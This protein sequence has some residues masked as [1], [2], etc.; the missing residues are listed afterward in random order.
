MII[1]KLELQG[2]KSFPEKTK[3]LFHSGVTVI[4]G[5][6]G[7]GKSNIVDALLWVLGGKRFRTLRGERSTDIIFNGH[8]N[9]P[10]LSMADVNLT[11]DDDHEEEII[12]NHRFFRS[13]E[14]EYRLN[15]KL[16]RLMDIQDCLWKKAIGELRYF[17]I[18][19]GSIGL[20]LN[21]KP[22]EK[23]VL[24]EEAAGTAFYK[25][26]KAQAESKL[27]SS[28]QNLIRLE[29]I[30]SE[31]SRAKNSLRRQASAATKYRK[32]RDRIRSLTSL[33]F[34]KKIEELEKLQ[35]EAVLNHEKLISEENAILSRIKEEERLLAAKRKESWD[36]EKSI[37]EG[38]ENLYSLK[39]QL[40]RLETD[41]DQ[42]QRRISLFDEKKQ[43]AK[44]SLQEI[45]EEMAH[46]EKESGEAAANLKEFEE[47]LE[48]KRKALDEA[49]QTIQ[50][51]Q[52]QK[53]QKQKNIESLRREYFE[54]L[55]TTTETKNEKARFEK[56]WEILLRQE[57]KLQ[58]QLQEEKTYLRQSQE[59][60]KKGLDEFEKAQK[61]R[62]EAKKDLEISQKELERL[63]STIQTLQ[64]NIADIN[65]KIEKER[66]HLQLL[67]KIEREERGSDLTKDLPS[68]MGML[69]DLIHSDPEYTPLVDIFWKEEV[70]AQLLRVEDFLKSLSQKELRGNFFLLHPKKKKEAPSKEAQDPRVLGRFKSF[71]KVSPNIKD[72]VSS[73]EEA[74]VVKDI[75]SAVELWLQFPSQNYVTL[76]GD[77]LLSSGL[78]K[79]GTKKEG[80]YAL[81]HD[82]KKLEENI[83]DLGKRIHPLE[84]ETQEKTEKK[85]DLERK[86]AQKKEGLFHLEKAL[87]ENEKER[88]LDQ[89][90]K[91]KIELHISTLENEL[92]IL[93]DN[94]SQMQRRLQS[95]ASRLEASQKEELALKNALQAAEI[96]F[97]AYQRENE[98]KRKTYF[99][100]K[101]EID[102]LQERIKNLNQQ[103][104]T[105]G[106]RRD[107]LQAK[108]LS[109]QEEIKSAEEK[110]KHLQED[111]HQLKQKI[112]NLEDKIKLKET[113][114]VQS[115]VHLKKTQKEQNDLEQR[116]EGLREEHEAKKEERVQWEIRKAEK[117]RDLANLEESCW[118]ELRKT[119]EEVKK[120]VT[121]DMLKE[122]NIQEKL[123]DAREK[124][125]KFK[126]VNLM[127][128]E[129]YLSQKKRYDFLIQQ[130]RDLRESIDTTK[131]A[132]KKID[133]ES[134][135]QFFKALAEINK[136]F[137]DVFALLFKGG[138]AEL[139]LTDESDPLES[140]VE[141]TA[142][143]PGKRLQSI[144]LLSGGE[145]SLTSLAFFFALFRYKPTPFCVLDEVD[146]ALDDVNLERY[147]NLMRRIKNQTQFILITHNFKT[148][149]V[150]DYIYGTTMAEPNITTIYSVKLDKKKPS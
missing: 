30:I 123:E 73:F 109:F 107:S 21:S 9:K 19:Q 62:G 95:I 135:A 77:L 79:L 17:V 88:A 150:A 93:G 14:S 106:R 75:K 83:A 127:A 125:Q 100:L 103:I 89:V 29:D 132:I 78:V 143:P 71:V 108:T 146:A 6:N 149:E 24:L 49:S 8:E 36:L 48:K 53:T 59:K 92:K 118:Q 46:L 117:D 67:K 99:E 113:H 76:Q 134:K 81:V 98:E 126:A 27:Q 90:A 128:E 112:K 141:I 96:E 131:Q 42:D 23:R 45:S 139:K 34:R 40:S 51:S 18:E 61:N 84:F 22:Q 2:F 28:E 39:S 91:E 7:T 114:L 35:K 111:T 13:G 97:E 68:S 129:E 31:V 43:K 26:R 56:E 94:K 87:E 119:L 140:G 122:M 66:H 136:N 121:P 69:A 63:F 57:E 60:I 74:A 4:T 115:E 47:S 85:Q 72:F 138:K 148:M 44:E 86:I 55:N 5:P 70:K 1:K 102:L 82:I 144:S 105:L 3:I 130:K 124:L 16:V 133:Q 64:E 25:D 33:Y 110:K 20:F 41:K 38:Q 52:E 137:Q 142:Q 10:P 37:K 101:S 147:L 65:E 12:I 32:L 104:Q 58:S 50:S 11:L 116:I 120:E 15:G 54:K 80:F 145:R